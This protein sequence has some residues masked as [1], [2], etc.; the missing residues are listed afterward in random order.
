[1]RYIMDGFISVY[2]GALAKRVPR[3]ARVVGKSN[4]KLLSSLW[5]TLDSCMALQRNLASMG[6]PGLEFCRAALM[7][8]LLVI[9]SKKIDVGTRRAL[10]R[11]ILESVM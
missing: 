1:M 2:Q 5:N 3:E 11:Y 7:V 4:S 6:K 9:I 8:M 10:Y